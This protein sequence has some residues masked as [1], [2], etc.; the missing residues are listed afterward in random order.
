MLIHNFTYKFG[1]T[2][3][4]INH[5]N[6]LSH[7]SAVRL[8]LV[9]IIITVPITIYILFNVPLKLLDTQMLKYGCNNISSTFNFTVSPYL[10]VD[11]FT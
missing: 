9:N 2:Y 3:L 7:S 6:N 8:I 4:S 5:N 11:N 1:R 10:L